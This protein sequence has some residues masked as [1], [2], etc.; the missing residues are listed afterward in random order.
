MQISKY[1]ERT[2]D[3]KKF[4]A[5]YRGWGPFWDQLFHKCW[6]HDWKR[7]KICTEFVIEGC[8]GDKATIR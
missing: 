6:C 7:G 5:D 2:P 1:V 4:G 8:I 3:R